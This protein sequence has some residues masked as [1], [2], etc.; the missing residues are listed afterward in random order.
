MAEDT[1]ESDS[2]GSDSSD[3]EDGLDMGANDAMDEGPVGP[4]RVALQTCKN[5][6]LHPA[7]Y[8]LLFFNQLGFGVQGLGL[9]V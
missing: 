3:A 8:T 9:L 7:F 6:S 1:G 4:A 5:V 2:S